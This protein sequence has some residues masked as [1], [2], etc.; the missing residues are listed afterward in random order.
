MCLFH[1]GLPQNWIQ[2]GK[3]ENF[4]ILR[5]GRH[6]G[7]RGT[8]KEYE[9]K[10]NEDHNDLLPRSF[11]NALMEKHLGFKEIPHLHYITHVQITSFAW[12]SALHSGSWMRN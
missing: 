5:V 2:C 10:I 4:S 3:K 8:C 12:K 7:K 1:T 9:E 6:F 11:Q